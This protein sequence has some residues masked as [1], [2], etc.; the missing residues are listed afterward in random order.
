MKI[1][2]LKDRVVVK[3]SSEELEKTP[4]GIYVP[5]VAKEK[6]QKGTVIEIGSEV[7]EVK[8]GDTVL[9]DKYAGSKIKV[10]DVEY[11]IIKEEEILG[12]VEK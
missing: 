2:P 3:Y 12:I 1:K 5:D 9:F 10:D 7:K 6:P 8:V 4:G 11:L